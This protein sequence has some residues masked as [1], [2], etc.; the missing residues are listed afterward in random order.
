MKRL[1]HGATKLVR[2]RVFGPPKDRTAAV[3]VL[4]EVVASGVN[5]IDT[6]DCYAPYVVNEIIRKALPPY[7]EDLV[8]VASV[9][10]QQPAKTPF[11]RRPLSWINCPVT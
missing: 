6:S 8:I 10:I 3:A 5:H 4:R 2:A 7:P 9:M 1:G 11:S